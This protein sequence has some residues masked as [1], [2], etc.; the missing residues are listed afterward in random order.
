M[1]RRFASAL[2]PTVLVVLAACGGVDRDGSRDNI[3]DELEQLGIDATPECVEGV[4]DQYSDDQLENIADNPE[5]AESVE[6]SVQ[7]VETC[8]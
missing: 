6:L 8:G 5:S 4:L 1:T 3:V 7:I 2:V